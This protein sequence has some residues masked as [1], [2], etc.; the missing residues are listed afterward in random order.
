VNFLGN[1]A[2]EAA[3][4]LSTKSPDKFARVDWT[5]SAVGNPI[6]SH[7]LAVAECTVEQTYVA[8]DHTI[9]IGLIDN[10]HR[11]SCSTPLIYHDRQFHYL[12]VDHTDLGAR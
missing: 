8:G 4:V 10:A 7:V 6:L 2:E 11:G 1:G 3:Q 12:Q 9:V 5:P